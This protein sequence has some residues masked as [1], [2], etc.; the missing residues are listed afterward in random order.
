MESAG[1]W[2]A[3]LLL[4]FYP[5]SKASLSPCWKLLHM[6]CSFFAFFSTLRCVEHPSVATWLEWGCGLLFVS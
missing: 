4:L 1:M 5:P 6:T 3:K 2:P